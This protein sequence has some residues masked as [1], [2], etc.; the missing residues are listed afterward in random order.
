MLTTQNIEQQSALLGV[1][2]SHRIRR[3][4]RGCD[5]TAGDWQKQAMLIAAPI[6]LVVSK[7]EDAPDLAAFPP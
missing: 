5:L 2:C 6:V 1:V 4:L 3:D 7:T